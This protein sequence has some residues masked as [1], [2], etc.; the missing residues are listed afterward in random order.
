M[1]KTI[2]KLKTDESLDFAINDLMEAIA[3]RKTFGPNYSFQD[4]CALDRYHRDLL[5]CV[6]EKCERN[7]KVTAAP[8]EFAL[9]V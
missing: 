6:T 8:S 1:N 3:A 9:F 2:V 5:L 4:K 7:A